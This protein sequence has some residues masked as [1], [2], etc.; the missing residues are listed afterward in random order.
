MKEKGNTETSTQKTQP[1]CPKVRF[2]T[3]PSDSRSLHLRPVI[4]ARFDFWIWP[5]APQ[6]IY[7]KTNTGRKQKSI[8]GQ[9]FVLFLAI[10]HGAG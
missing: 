8:V 10:I 3:K 4:F 7:S 5:N 2:V 1:S 6:G 9:H